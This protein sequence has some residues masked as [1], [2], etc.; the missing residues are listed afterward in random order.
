M[1]KHK[2]NISKGGWCKCHILTFLD[3]TGKKGETLS[4]SHYFT[5]RIDNRFLW[6]S[7]LF[8]HSV[9]W[10]VP[11][12]GWASI[13]YHTPDAF[14]SRHRA[15]EQSLGVE[16]ATRVLERSAAGARGRR[17]PVMIWCRAPPTPTCK[18]RV[19][20]IT[21]TCPAT[22]TSWSWCCFAQTQAGH[23]LICPLNKQKRLGAGSDRK[24]GLRNS[25]VLY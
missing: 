7:L 8:H 3:I 5:H 21:D 22:Q 14:F 9:R 1:T 2:K 4:S 25:S 17:Y 11:P 20:E 23:S 10:L 15:D 24:P 13:Q 12:G 6:L 19:G 18:Y 16:P